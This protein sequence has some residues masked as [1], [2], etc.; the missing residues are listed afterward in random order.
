[1]QR[2]PAFQD[3]SRDHFTGLLACLHV[4]RAVEGHETAPPLDAATAGLL[5]LWHKELR[6]HF[7]EEDEDL[8]PSL[9][10]AGADLLAR[11]RDDHARLRAA[12]AD[13]EGQH[14][15]TFA[16]VAKDLRDHIRWEEDVLFE[17]LQTHLDEPALQA[18]WQRS[19]R[20]RIA[21]RGPGSVQEPSPSKR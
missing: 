5:D 8:Q 11:L 2:H 21:H 6:F 3:L 18:L 13:L 20:F 4:T 15:A 16:A 19:R 9:E 17:W 1:V 12:F 10:G 7:D 14:A